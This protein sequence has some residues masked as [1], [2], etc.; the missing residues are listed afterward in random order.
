MTER[1]PRVFDSR[2]ALDPGNRP[3]PR[4]MPPD[5]GQ[6]PV[7]I[8]APVD[9]ET[10]SLMSGYRSG[11]LP[12]KPDSLAAGELYIELGTEPGF[13]PRLWVGAI[14]DE[15]FAG[16]ITG[17]VP[18]GET[19]P[20]V[21]PVDGPATELP[22]NVDV[23]QVMPDEAHPGDTLTCTMG[24]WQNMSDGSYRYQWQHDQTR[25]IGTDSA[26]YVVVDDDV[27]GEISCI[28]TAENAI[29]ETEAPASNAATIT[30]TP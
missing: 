23:P 12:P 26:S 18:A 2:N 4:D 11:F 10:V 7:T 15:S 25:P 9:P 6:P 8:D 19:L 21:P 22:V 20:D 24:N 5:D 27:D 29:G 16:N 1:K 17:L 28:V 3:D 13:A 14:R 30:A